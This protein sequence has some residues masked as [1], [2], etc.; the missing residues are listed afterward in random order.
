MKKRE[1]T[2]VVPKHYTFNIKLNRCIFFRNISSVIV[3]GYYITL[4]QSPL[5]PG[6]LECV[7]VASC[8]WVVE[9]SGAIS[10][11]DP[12]SIFIPLHYGGWPSSCDTCEI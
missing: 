10:I 11:N 2:M 3:R 1:K 9:N 5:S 12:F 7:G 6:K 4:V 8:H